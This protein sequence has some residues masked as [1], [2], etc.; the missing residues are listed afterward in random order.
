METLERALG[1]SLYHSKVA[2]L[3]VWERAMEPWTH[4]V[5]A[6]TL[7]LERSIHDWTIYSVLAGSM[8]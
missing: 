2:L 6:V 4:W 7:S 5:L 8:P 1:P 3:C